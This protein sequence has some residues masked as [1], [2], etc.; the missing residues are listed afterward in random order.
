MNSKTIY[1][2]LLPDGRVLQKSGDVWV[3]IE[4]PGLGP[5]F[6]GPGVE[7]TYDPENPPSTKE[8][9]ARMKRVSFAKHLRF[10]FGFT[11]K[12]FAK[13]YH[14]PIGTL[15][16][17]E[18]HRCEPDA[19]ARALLKVIAVDPEGVAKAL[20]SGPVRVAAE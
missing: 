15:R 4:I 5:N 12:E 3:E 13:L 6:P 16:D 18:Q 7:P 10:K 11:Q 19:P 2:K 17:W 14:I 20:N 1:S 8:Q 9:L